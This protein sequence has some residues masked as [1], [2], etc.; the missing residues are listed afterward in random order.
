MSTRS[1]NKIKGENTR[2]GVVWVWGVVNFIDELEM[3]SMPRQKFKN[4]LPEVSTSTERIYTKITVGTENKSRV[5]LTSKD[6][7]LC[8]VIFIYLS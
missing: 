4:G 2:V 1:F 6:N 8:I 7:T 5:V 3:S